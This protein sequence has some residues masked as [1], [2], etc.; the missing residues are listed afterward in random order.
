MNTKIN[1]QEV[2]NARQTWLEARR[3]GVGG[4]DVAAILGLSKYKSPYQLW[5]FVNRLQLIKLAV[6]ITS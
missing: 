6:H 4:S 5:L 1:L 2:E 3:L